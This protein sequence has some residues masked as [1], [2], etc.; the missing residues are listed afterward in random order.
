LNAYEGAINRNGN[1]SIN[2]QEM[3]LVPGNNGITLNG[4]TADIMPRWW[5]I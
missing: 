4:V 2:F 1:I 5:E 3:D